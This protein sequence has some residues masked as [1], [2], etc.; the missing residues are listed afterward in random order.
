MIPL[1]AS[2]DKVLHILDRAIGRIDLL[3]VRDVVSHVNLRTV[4]PVFKTNGSAAWTTIG[5]HPQAIYS[6]HMGETQMASTPRS[7]K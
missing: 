6:T 5:T 7:F 3:V 4:K 1:M 2:F